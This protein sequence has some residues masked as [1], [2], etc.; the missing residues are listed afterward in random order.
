MKQPKNPT[1]SQKIAIASAGL[2][3]KNWLV[4]SEDKHSIVLEHKITGTV[5]TLR[6]EVN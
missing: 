6:K 1:R 3:A 5:R 4:V 2:N